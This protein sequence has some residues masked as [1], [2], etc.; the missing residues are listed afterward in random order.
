MHRPHSLLSCD[1]RQ[2]V[3]AFLSTSWDVQPHALS[4]ISSRWRDHNQEQYEQLTSVS[5]WST[6][7]VSVAASSTKSSKRVAETYPAP[8]EWQLVFATSKPAL[9]DSPDE[10]RADS[11]MLG[12]SCF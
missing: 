10:Y 6:V 2:T 12:L 7:S 8:C 9:C 11:S 3:E 5:D 4:N 1:E